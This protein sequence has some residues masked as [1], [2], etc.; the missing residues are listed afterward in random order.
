MSEL[1]EQLPKLVS[2]SSFLLRHFE[3]FEQSTARGLSIIP[4]RELHVYIYKGEHSHNGKD[5]C[6]S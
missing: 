5:M 6:H 3:G 4:Q 2:S 1:L